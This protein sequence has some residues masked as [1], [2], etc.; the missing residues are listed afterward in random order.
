MEITKM[1][2]KPQK[3]FAIAALIAVSS[4]QQAPQSF[5][6]QFETIDILIENGAI[7]DGLGNDAVDGDVVIVGD[8]IVFV[9]DA[10]FSAEDFASR[11]V[12]RIDASGKVVAPGF[13][14]LHSHG[15]ISSPWV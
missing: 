6:P 1:I 8:Q 15:R 10:Q 12:R 3:L 9:G 13:I 5:L 4:C 2:E 14:D 7:L 11:V